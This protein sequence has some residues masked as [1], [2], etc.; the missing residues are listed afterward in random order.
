MTRLT[1]ALRRVKF[2][3]VDPYAYQPEP[4]AEGIWPRFQAVDALVVDMIAGVVPVEAIT[5]STLFWDDDDSGHANDTYQI[6]KAANTR[7]HCQLTNKESYATES[8][9][10]MN[11]RGDGLQ[12]REFR[13][14]YQSL[15]VDFTAS[16]GL[17][18]AVWVTEEPAIRY[19]AYYL[20]DTS[21][22]DIL[23][24]LKVNSVVY[25][26]DSLARVHDDVIVPGTTYVVPRYVR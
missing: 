10:H 13:S 16:D 9:F 26:G 14:H 20:Q 24:Q 23:E 1:E 11:E 2:D 15:K 17:K 22:G 18:G 7:F 12:L 5:R 21:G 3:S 25:E 8:R 19:A 4:S 6:L